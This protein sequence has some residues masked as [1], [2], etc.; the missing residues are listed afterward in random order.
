MS[1]RYFWNVEFLL[2][3]TIYSM[4]L[5]SQFEKNIQLPTLATEGWGGGGGYCE[6][7]PGGV[8]L[9]A[10]PGGA[11]KY[12]RCLSRGDGIKH[13]RVQGGRIK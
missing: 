4:G 7:V 3:P 9:N 6:Y 8:R 11:R 2:F 12:N 13:K 10:C 5:T 1:I